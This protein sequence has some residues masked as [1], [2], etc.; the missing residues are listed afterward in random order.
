MN[1]D[2]RKRKGG[3]EDGKRERK[4]A[5]KK[6]KKRERRKRKKGRN[7]EERI[8]ALLFIFACLKKP[9][10]SPPRFAH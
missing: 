9:L 2:E 8:K 5:R 3:R 7:K 4:K 1:S 10:E 6:E